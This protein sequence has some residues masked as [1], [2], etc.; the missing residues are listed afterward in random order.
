MR[1][2]VLSD[3]HGQHTKLNLPEGDL[4]VHSG[5]FSN[6]GSYK[7]HY[8]F[9]QWFG[10]LPYKHKILVPGN[11]DIY[12]QQQPILIKELCTEN[13]V[14]FLVDNMIEIE[15]KLIYGSPWTPRYGRWSWMKERGESIAKVWENIPNDLDLLI[16]H[17][18]PHGI[19]DSNIFTRFICGCEELLKA[20]QDKK[21][22]KHVF[23]HIHAH[24]G[25]NVFE[26]STHFYNAAICDEDYKPNNS[27]TTFD[28]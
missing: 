25:K 19:L 7:D 22:Y 12:S 14:H 28:I 3:T 18:P 8:T 17:G 9:I 5:D 26:H 1:V 16:T 20:I 10:N 23:G 24:G 6:T 13:N 11:H 15:G 21:P 27:I 4:I 2:V